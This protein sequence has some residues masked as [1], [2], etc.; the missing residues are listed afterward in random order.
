MLIL[1]GYDI[2]DS[3]RREGVAALLEAC[4]ARVQYSVFECQ[5]ASRVVLEELLAAIRGVVDLD[6]D[7]VRVYVLGGDDAEAMI[8]GNRRLQERQSFWIL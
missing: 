2:G 8:V 6:D 7:Q 5:V 3:R 1:V 4:G